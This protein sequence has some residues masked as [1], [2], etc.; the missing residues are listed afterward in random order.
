MTD[1]VTKKPVVVQITAQ[2]KV[3]K[4]PLQAAQGIAARL[5]GG[6]AA[7]EPGGERRGGGGGQGGAGAGGTA[8]RPRRWRGPRW[9]G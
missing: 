1:L 9:C 3:V 8:G 2:S 4:I 5:K 7:G 6:A